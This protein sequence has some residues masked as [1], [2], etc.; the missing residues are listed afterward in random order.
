MS[1]FLYGIGD[2]EA[3]IQIS[4]ISGILVCITELDA[5][6]VVE[7]AKTQLLSSKDPWKFDHI[8]RI[9][10]VEEVVSTELDE[11]IVAA[12]NIASRKIYEKEEEEQEPSTLSRL[13]SPVQ[14]LQK[15]K[16]EE[17]QHKVEQLS[18]VDYTAGSKASFRVTVEKR[19]CTTIRS[20]EIISAIAE[21]FP[22]KRVDLVNPNWIILVEVLGKL[23]GI[24]VIRPN[25]I[26]SFAIEKRKLIL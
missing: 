22:D 25:Q 2:A 6:Y 5:F 14:H 16:T 24:S 1:S 23:T 8:L 13:I 11:I 26:F 7:K 4:N 12:T 17:R 19:H 3:K 20:Y 15:A 10:P 21:H 18:S 9:I